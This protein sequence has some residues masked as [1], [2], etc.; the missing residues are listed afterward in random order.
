MF[1]DT[2][3]MVWLLLL[4]LTVAVQGYPRRYRRSGTTE[5]LAV[6]SGDQRKGKSLE[7]FTESYIDSPPVFFD[8]AVGQEYI[9]YDEELAAALANYGV[10]AVGGEEDNEIMSRSRLRPK[11]G[12]NSPIYYIRLPPTP[13]V[14]IPGVG[15][16]SQP[17]TLRPPPVVQST[18]E[19][20]FINLPTRFVS[21]GK[22]TGVYLWNPAAEHPYA[23]PK[24]L[25]QDS[26]MTNLN[27]GPYV[28]N[29]KPSDIFLLR[30][31]YNSLY[32][33]ALQN[34]YP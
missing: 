1:Q 24:P 9:D 10:Q 32:A 25:A 34:F 7:Y 16:V 22:P 13:Y 5:D 20:N 27:K 19:S 11:P 12:A 2:M 3:Q 29:G 18:P 14:F 6:K 17:P 33:D 30:N 4:S 31:T 26:L 23:R 15:Y 21:N 8:S 28:F